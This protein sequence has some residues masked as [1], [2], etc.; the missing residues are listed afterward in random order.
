MNSA[1]FWVPLGLAA[2]LSLAVTTAPTA[3]PVKSC[4]RGEARTG[5]T[6]AEVDAG[7]LGVGLPMVQPVPPE[8]P[9]PLPIVA[10][11]EPGDPSSFRIGVVIYSF[12]NGKRSKAMAK[13]L[14][15]KSMQTAGT[16][17]TAAVKAGDQD[18]DADYGTFSA[19]SFD[20]ELEASIV[21]I[22]VGRVGGPIETPRS[23]WIVKRIK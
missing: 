20:T 10:A 6:K 11:P 2:G 21:A 16:D 7:S 5:Q 19:R 23:Y 1:A 15:D 17:F 3:E 22:P 18:S 12:E 9:A 4:C 14:A 13:A 8:A